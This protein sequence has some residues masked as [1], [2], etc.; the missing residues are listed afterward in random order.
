MENQT[1]IRFL[2]RGIEIDERTQDYITRKID[3]IGKIINT[4]FL[5]ETA[6]ELN[7]KGKFGVKVIIK[8]PYKF[9]RAASTTESIE[10]SVDEIEDI[11]HNEIVRDLDR[12]RTLIKRGARSIKKKT[13]IDRHAR[14]RQ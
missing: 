10:G 12:R 13:V 7:K 1:N 11:L 2:F 6:I 3:A 9:Y 4:I 8:T 14:F 5:S